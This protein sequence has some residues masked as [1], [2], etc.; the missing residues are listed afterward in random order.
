MFVGRVF[1][2]LKNLPGALGSVS[3]IIGHANGNIVNL[4]I[5]RRMNDFFDLIVDV[6]VQ[7]VEH[8]NSIMASLRATALVSYIERK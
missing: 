6:N 3:N 4:K 5:L 1:M 2:V 8:L 7:N